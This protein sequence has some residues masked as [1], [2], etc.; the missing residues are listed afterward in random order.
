[1]SNILVVEDE[2]RLRWVIV[3]YLKNQGVHPTAATT[4]Q[5][6]ICVLDEEKVDLV[7]L[8]LKLINGDGLRVLK[9]IR[10]SPDLSH[11][12]VLAVSAWDMEPASYDYLDPGDYLIK[13]FDIRALNLMMRQLL[14]L[15]QAAHLNV[16]E[17]HL[18]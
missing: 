8:D 16:G 2:A 1:M 11:I 7:V 18:Q 14:D 5:E 10:E 17:E 15:P 3:A 9:Y 4:F 12:P 6:A 13:P